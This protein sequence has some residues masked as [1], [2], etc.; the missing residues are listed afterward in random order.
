[1]ELKLY[2]LSRDRMETA[3]DNWLFIRRLNEAIAFDKFGFF[4]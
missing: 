1:M 2:M 3:C 4:F